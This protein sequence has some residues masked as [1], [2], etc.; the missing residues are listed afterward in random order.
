MQQ[1]LHHHGGRGGE[2]PRSLSAPSLQ[3]GSGQVQ[4]GRLLHHPGHPRR[5]HRQHH[6]VPRG[7]DGGD[8]VQVRL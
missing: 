4:E 8:R 3:G 5:R 6:Q 2:V 1:H 7:E